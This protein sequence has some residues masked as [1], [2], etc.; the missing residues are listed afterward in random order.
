MSEDSC[1]INY[2]DSESLKAGADYEKSAFPCAELH[3][4]DK[5]KIDCEYL[6]EASH[7]ADIINKLVAEKMPVKTKS[8]YRPVMYKDI[9]ILM[10]GLNDADD[11]FD[12]LTKK[13]YPRVLSEKRRLFPKHRN[14]RDA[15]VS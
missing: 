15:V 11:Y 8:G 13:K 14:K 6:P 1:G 10:R 12:A 2:D 5:S 4:V 7:I 3:I 9:C